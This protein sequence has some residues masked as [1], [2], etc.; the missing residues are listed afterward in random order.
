MSNT[1]KDLGRMLSIAGYL[2]IFLSM[3]VGRADLKTTSSVLFGMS[4]LLISVRYVTDIIYNVSYGKGHILQAV[5]VITGFVFWFGIA[6]ISPFTEKK[7]VLIIILE[8]A[9]LFI[10]AFFWYRQLIRKDI[11][12]DL[13]RITV[14]RIRY[15]WGIIV[16]I[17]YTLAMSLGTL[18]WIP[19]WDDLVYTNA[20][21]DARDFDFILPDIDLLDG[22]LSYAV[23]ILLFPGVHMSRTNPYFGIRII[24][25][26]YLL[27]D[28]VLIYFIF[29]K[30]LPSLSNIEITILS[31]VFLSFAPV[32]GIQSPNLDYIGMILLIAMVFFYYYGYHYMFMISAILLCFTKEPLALLYGGFLAGMLLKEKIIRRGESKRSCT[33]K[34]LLFSMPLIMWLIIFSIFAV[35]GSA[36][37]SYN[38]QKIWGSL[39]IQDSEQD[40]SSEGM[41]KEKVVKG[42][43]QIIGEIDSIHESIQSKNGVHSRYPY[44]ISKLIEMFVFH[45]LW[46]PFSLMLIFYSVRNLKNLKNLT[47]LSPIISAIIIAGIT[48]C[49]CRT[50]D[51]YRNVVAGSILVLIVSLTGVCLFIKK[52]TLRNRLLI[53]LCVLFNIE[54]YTII[55]P[56]TLFNRDVYNSGDGKIVYLDSD[57]SKDIL[58]SPVIQV[59]RQ[60]YDYG[61]LIETVLKKINYDENTLVLV[62]EM[63]DKRNIETI[64]GVYYGGGL[65]YDAEKKKLITMPCM[66]EDKTEVLWGNFAYNGDVTV[67]GRDKSEV[68]F[69]RV[70]LILFPF[71]DNERYIEGIFFQDLKLKSAQN[72]HYNTWSATAIELKDIDIYYLEKKIEREKQ[73]GEDD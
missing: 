27:I 64:R 44:V 16:C 52:R 49:V 41:D 48:N 59:N 61:N 68:S 50:D 2:L 56:A 9:T 46:I 53:I 55:D 15:N 5:I 8:A 25:L 18:K 10:M 3:A 54:H 28:S 60:G 32:I 73:E 23:N 29:K 37:G 6:L 4:L 17:A 58:I 70:F 71:L 13:N 42:P 7:H 35:K 47:E 51:I 19:I 1:R 38:P 11:L 66:S 72:I 12:K 63:N 69:D 43:E 33:P 65:W 34:V 45:F 20:L 40:D 39:G 31:V 26:F 36:D 14:K 62:P 22:H 57:S 21:V 24:L 67:I 30:L